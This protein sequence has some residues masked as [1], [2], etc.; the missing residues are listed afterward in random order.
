MQPSRLLITALTL[1]LLFFAGCLTK[2]RT[3]YNEVSL[4]SEEPTSE[5]TTDAKSQELATMQGKT[6]NLW[7]FYI[8]NGRAHYVLWPFIKKSPG[9]FAILPVYNYDHGIHDIALICT[10]SPESGEYRL[11]PLFYRSPKWWMFLP[12]AYAYDE[13]FGCPLLFNINEDFNSILNFFWG[14]NNWSLFPFAFYN[15]YK[16]DN[17]SFRSLLYCQ[18][19]HTYGDWTTRNYSALLS[20]FLTKIETNAKTNARNVH[21]WLIPFWFR[22]YDA[23][24]GEDKQRWHHNVFPLYWS[25]GRETGYTP[26]SNTLFIPLFFKSTFGEKGSRLCTPLVGYGKDAERRAAWWYFLNVGAAESDIEHQRYMGEVYDDKGEHTRTL[27]TPYRRHES[28]AWALPF[29]FHSETEGISASTWTPLSY[30]CTT[31][32]N[33]TL[34]VGPL[35]LGFPF[36]AK[37]SVD[38]EETFFFPVTRRQRWYTTSALTGEKER[39]AP[40]GTEWKL[41]NGLLYEYKTSQRL[42]LGPLPP[43]IAKHL[44]TREGRTWHLPLL[45]LGAKDWTD[46][47][48]NLYPEDTS[49]WRGYGLL[50]TYEKKRYRPPVCKDF[51]RC[52]DKYSYGPYDA[53]THT[54]GYSALLTSCDKTVY[55]DYAEPEDSYESTDRGL[56]LNAIHWG[57]NTLGARNFSLGW[58]LIADYEKDVWDSKTSSNTSFTLLP[59]GLLWE[60]DNYKTTTSSSEEHDLLWSLLYCYDRCQYKERK[61]E[62]CWKASHARDCT[63]TSCSTDHHAEQCRIT[64]RS[65]TLDHRILLGI[66]WL[67]EIADRQE[68]HADQALACDDVMKTKPSEDSYVNQIYTLL[69]LAYYRNT[70]RDGSYASRSLLGLLYDHTENVSDNTETLGILGYLYRYNRYADGSKSHTIFPFITYE[71]DAPAETTSVSFLYKLFRHEKTPE[72]RNIWLLWIPIW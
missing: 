10:L 13:G 33:S 58:S 32:D 11:W 57:S 46:W 53:T 25:W 4:F 6:I 21:Q 1:S 18:G 50:T 24:D 23:P 54:W 20:L 42:P 48:D 12:F 40:C 17:Y 36:S 63:K 60:T 31:T 26:Y 65:D 5:A 39:Y 22:G 35:G 9:C 34:K 59:L 69:G 2:S 62:K 16:N 64:T 55:T 68:W 29:W 47:R 56:L 7:P 71:E 52:H 66:L 41:L 43:D 30:A 49:T 28:A 15:T 61:S 37:R 70:Q 3:P 19:R 72:G 14:K 45:R 8:G 67:H 51:R 44:Y 27:Y 38:D